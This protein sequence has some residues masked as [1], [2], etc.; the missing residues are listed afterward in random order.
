MLEKEEKEVRSR[1]EGSRQSTGS[2]LTYLIESG[3][4]K[5]VKP[6]PADIRVGIALALRSQNHA[7]LDSR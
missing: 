1:D 6:T 2:S 4:Y 3:R 5:L 7:K